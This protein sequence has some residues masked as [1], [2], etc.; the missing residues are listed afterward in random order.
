MIRRVLALLAVAWFLGF[1]WFAVALP[2]PLERATGDAAVVPTGAA[3]RIERGIELLE[4]GKVEA[5]LVTGVDPEVRPGEF[6]AEFEVP[7]GLMECCI[8]LGSSAVDTRG[9]A[10]ETAEWLEQR[11]FGSIR[12]VTS[13]WHMRRARIELART[14]P[15]DVTIRED[16]V[17][18]EPSLRIL[19]LEYHKLLASWVS[20]LWRS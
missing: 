20:G 12:L 13:D 11:R 14:L 15:T 19:F 18:T 2:V 1:L 10:T 5:M 16:A 7:P 9:N 4:V 8:T 3:G 6:A 17:P